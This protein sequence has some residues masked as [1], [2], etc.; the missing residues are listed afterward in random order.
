MINEL[1]TKMKI[2]KP[3]N[4]VFEAIV[5]PAIMSNYWFSSESGRWEEGKTVTL[6][7][8]EYHAQ[9]DINVL[10]IKENQKIVYRWPASDEGTVVTITLKALD[11]AST[12]IEVN[13]KGWKA[14]DD[15]LI[16]VLVGQ[17]EGWVYALTCL[18]AYLEYG[19]RMKG[20]LVK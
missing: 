7:Y 20:A 10:E 12:V 11:H 16:S 3:V 5:D 14:E 2:L 9:V 6:R 17:K 19:V 15:A 4:E 8:E 1:V 13:E 18:K